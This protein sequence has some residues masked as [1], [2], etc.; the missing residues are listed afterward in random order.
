MCVPVSAPT[1]T[2]DVEIEKGFK[3]QKAALIDPLTGK[4]AADQAKRDAQKKADEEKR[5]QAEAE[6]GQ[7]AE[8]KSR[9]LERRQAG[10]RASAA[11]LSARRS[12][13]DLQ[14]RA[15]TI[16]TGGSGVQTSG[17]IGRKTLLGQ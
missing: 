14:G 4:D 11:A 7:V 1:G 3:T 9:E 12:R 17:T 10:T 6:A 2:P 8:R 13:A 15:S 16:L 5:K